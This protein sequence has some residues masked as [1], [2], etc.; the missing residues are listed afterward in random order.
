MQRVVRVSVRPGLSWVLSKSVCVRRLFVQSFVSWG[1]SP[2]DSLF[3]FYAASFVEA[4]LAVGTSLA[5][6]PVVVTLHAIADGNLVRL[7]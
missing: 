2:R 6:F 4:D 5:L 7:A 3:A 1:Y